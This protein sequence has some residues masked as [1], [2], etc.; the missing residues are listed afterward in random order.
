MFIDIIVADQDT[1]W[2]TLYILLIGIII[3]GLLQVLI[4][5]KLHNFF[6]FIISAI[7]EMSHLWT[8]IYFLGNFQNVLTLLIGSSV[9]FLPILVNNKIKKIIIG[10]SQKHPISNSVLRFT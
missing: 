10:L 1:Y 5:Y 2:E 3:C 4:N 9:F 6:F 8:D 7:W